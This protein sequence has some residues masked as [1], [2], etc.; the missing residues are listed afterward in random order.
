MHFQFMTKI[1]GTYLQLNNVN[2]SCAYK[3]LFVFECHLI[4]KDTALIIFQ[5][6][7]L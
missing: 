2:D 4:S 7:A 5:F 6:S 1:D 3:G